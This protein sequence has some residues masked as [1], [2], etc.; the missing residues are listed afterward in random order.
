MLQE[1][2]QQACRLGAS[3]ARVIS[4]TEIVIEDDLAKL[5]QPSLCENYGLSPGCPPHVPGPAGFRTL[6]ENALHSLVFKLDVPSEA[7]FSIERQEIFKLLHQIAAGIEE[8]AIEMGYSQSR[9]FAGGSCKKTFCR[10]HAVCRV[11]NGEGECRY[12]KDARP[13]MSGFGINVSKLMQAAGW[14]MHRA[15]GPG[16]SDTL[17]LG[18][19]C[20][21]VLIA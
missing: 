6:M 16:T 1:L 4:T 17:K 9:G 3:D 12:P 14:A 5:C 10:D 7:L 2:V 19:V 21:L 18:T 15:A 13:S 20:G 11:L 8:S